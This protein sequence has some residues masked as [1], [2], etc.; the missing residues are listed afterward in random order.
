MM[1]WMW[2]DPLYWGAAAGWSGPESEAA[3]TQAAVSD[4][5]PCVKPEATEV[6]SIGP[7][8]FASDSRCDTPF[9]D[10]F[11]GDDYADAARTLISVRKSVSPP[12]PPEVISGTTWQPRSPPASASEPLLA[13]GDTA[14]AVT[15][16]RKRF[17]GGKCAV[18][19]CHRPTDAQACALDV[20]CRIH[21]EL[22][23]EYRRQKAIMDAPK[24]QMKEKQQ[25]QRKSR[26]MARFRQVLPGLL[27]PVSPVEQEQKPAVRQAGRAHHAAS[28]HR[29]TRRAGTKRKANAVEIKMEPAEMFP[30]LL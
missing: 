13:S 3:S 16:N 1:S 6:G 10:E 21:A 11:L 29:S 17:V 12:L 14:A 15:F 23:P 18:M 20:L 28:A 8:A 19:T 5:L 22:E 4:A 30:R 27:R 7:A 25:L 2:G 26:P 24:L 9:A